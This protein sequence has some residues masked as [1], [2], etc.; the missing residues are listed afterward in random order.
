MSL[1]LFRY[2]ESSQSSSWTW[3]EWK[4]GEECVEGICAVVPQQEKRVRILH[5][6]QWTA[7]LR[8]YSVS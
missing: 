4:I 6:T 7:K 5:K 2:L 1:F 8:E 3:E